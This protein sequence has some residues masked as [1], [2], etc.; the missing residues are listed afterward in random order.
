MSLAWSRMYFTAALAASR[1]SVKEPEENA[2][3]VPPR[4]S[5]APNRPSTVI[6]RL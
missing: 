2:C 4:A 6:M 3:G 5:P 1:P